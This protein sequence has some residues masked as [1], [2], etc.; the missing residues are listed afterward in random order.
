MNNSPETEDETWTETQD[1]TGRVVNYL[2]HPSPVPSPV[3]LTS[4]ANPR[5]LE[6]EFP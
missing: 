3:Y 4:V 6:I 1:E 2:L 5:F